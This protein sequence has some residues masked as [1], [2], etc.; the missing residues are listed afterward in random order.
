M[1]TP[2]AL[3]LPTHAVVRHKSGKTY[4]VLDVYTQSCLLGEASGPKFL[5][6]PFP[7]RLGVRGW[8]DGEPFGPWRS[9]RAADCT[10]APQA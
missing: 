3:A 2:D 4:L 9:L 10:A 6:H 7:A 8:R 5:S 1:T